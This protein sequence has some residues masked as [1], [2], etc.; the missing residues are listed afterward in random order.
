MPTCN[1]DSMYEPIEIILGGKTYK[2][3][4]ITKS[5]LDTVTEII[6][7]EEKNPNKGNIS[8]IAKQLSVF[9]DAPVEVL[10]AIDVRKLAATSRFIMKSIQDDVEG[11]EKNVEKV[12]EKP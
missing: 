9:L 2:I 3:E 10:E 7:Q 1:V 8:I 11:S 4:S 5:M 6:A 12:E